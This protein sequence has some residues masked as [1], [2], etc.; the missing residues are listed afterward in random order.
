LKGAGIPS[1]IHGESSAE[2]TIEVMLFPLA[3]SSAE[4][5]KSRVEP[6]PLKAPRILR[7]W[8]LASFD[9]PTAA[10]VWALSFAWAAQVQLPHWAPVLIA[11]VTWAVYVADRLLDAR[12]ALRS[13][14]D[15]ALR[16]RH[17]FHW[18]HRRILTPL[19]GVAA[20]GAAALVLLQMPVGARERN[21]VLA[22]AA[23]VY[24]SGVHGADWLPRWARRIGSKEL[25]VGVLFTA[26]CAL[27]ALS[28]VHG[29]A[30]FATIGSM[31]PLLLLAG[32][33]AALAWLNCKAIDCWESGSVRRIEFAGAAL[34]AIGLALAAG[35]SLEQP[36]SLYSHALYPHAGAMSVAGAVSACLIALLHQWRDRL[37]PLA[38][39]GAADLALLTPLVCLAR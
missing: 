20:V 2:S 32:F 26:G 38:L 4:D 30:P 34:A 27:P 28:R 9:A 14:E 24:F 1:P 22:A 33:F 10:V 15:S 13:G 36:Q 31:A 16:E 8:H 12:A 35:L 29:R 39:R 25:A 17:F 7:F 3:S 5:R 23:L 11:L 21:S 6:A 18:R 19:A 37:S